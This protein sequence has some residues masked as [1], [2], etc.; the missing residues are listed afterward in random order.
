MAA[1]YSD[2]IANPSDNTALGVAYKASVGV[3]HARTRTSIAR[4]TGL[5][6][7]TD[8]VRMISLRSGDRLLSLELA[9]D[10][11]CTA[12]AVDVGLYLAGEAHS[13]AVADAD[14]FASAMVVSTETDLLDCFVE[15]TTLDGVDR[16]RT[17]WEIATLGGGTNYTEDPF[18]LFDIV[19]IPSTSLTVAAGELTLKA[20]YT[21]GD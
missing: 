17:L 13:G 12:G 20:V 16:G 4:A 3:S 7:T 2:L 6:L 9:T 10:G 18:L 5:F 11:A 14:L 1:Y 8:I 19:I 15:S 21:A